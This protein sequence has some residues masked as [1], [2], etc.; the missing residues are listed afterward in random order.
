MQAIICSLILSNASTTWQPLE[1]CII[2][3]GGG[4][5]FARMHNLREGVGS[6]CRGSAFNR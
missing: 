3:R 1:G 5:I 2:S 6:S 4:G